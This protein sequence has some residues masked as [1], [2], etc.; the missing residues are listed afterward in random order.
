M[1]KQVRDELTADGVNE[2]DLGNGIA[3]IEDLQAAGKNPGDLSDAANEEIIT[4][5]TGA[6]FAG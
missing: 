4:E 2:N 1:D 5:V 6:N 3:T